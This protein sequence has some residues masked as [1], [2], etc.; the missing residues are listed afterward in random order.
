MRHRA[1]TLGGGW[2]RMWEDGVGERILRRLAWLEAE[3][4]RIA[5]AL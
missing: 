1:Q 3:G 2:A 5:A 4:S